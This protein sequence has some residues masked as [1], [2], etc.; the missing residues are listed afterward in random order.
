LWTSEI[1]EGCQFNPRFL[2]SSQL[3]TEL[4]FGLISEIIDK[5]GLGSVAP[6]LVDDLLVARYLLVLQK[7]PDS[8]LCSVTCCCSL[9][10]IAIE[11][12]VVDADHYVHLWDGGGFHHYSSGFSR[13]T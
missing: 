5:V 1:A 4:T 12:R 6:V 2:G 8:A 11:D 10:L 3:G 9:R 13:D 7:V